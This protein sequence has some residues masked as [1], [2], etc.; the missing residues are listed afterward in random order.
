ME[1]LRLLGVGPAIPTQE[2]SR[3]SGV[4]WIGFSMNAVSGLL[5]LNA[6]PTK[7][8]TKRPPTE[9]AGWPS[10]VE[11]ALAWGSLLSW[12]GAIVATTDPR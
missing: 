8:L 10:R 4:L 2:M 11:L 1:A 6:Y 12:S 7:A 5:L 3:F 9:A